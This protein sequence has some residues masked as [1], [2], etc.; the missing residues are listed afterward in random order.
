[1]FWGPE[2]AQ[3]RWPAGVRRG[4][5][6]GPTYEYLGPHAPGGG[7]LTALAPSRGRVPRLSPEVPPTPPVLGL[8]FQ[9]HNGGRMIRYS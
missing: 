1:M 2:I 5:E 6:V 8:L 4:K 3:N 7:D 9:S